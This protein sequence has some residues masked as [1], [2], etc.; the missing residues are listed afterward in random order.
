MANVV[1]QNDIMKFM[2]MERAV[3]PSG[4]IFTPSAKDWAKEHGIEIIIDDNKNKDDRLDNDTG[5]EGINILD[6]EKGKVIQAVTKALQENMY[7]TGQRLDRDELVKIV[8][9]CLERLG[10]RVEK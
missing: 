5:S 7:K 2:G 6:G 3:F 10:H 1:S 8:S 9:R 4:T